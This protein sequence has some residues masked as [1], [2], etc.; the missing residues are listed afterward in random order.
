M[1]KLLYL[2][3]LLPI[4]LWG[5]DGTVLVIDKLAPKNGAF[6]GIVDSSQTVNNVT[7]FN[8]N[9]SASETTVQEALDVLDDLAIGSGGSSVYPA[10]STI[11]ADYGI[12]ASTIQID[13]LSGVLKATGG[14]VSGSATTSDLPEGTN[15]YFTT[16]RATSSIS[17][18]APLTYESGVIG[19]T[20]YF[21]LT[22]S[23]TLL[24][25][26]S[27]TATYL[28][29]SSATETYLQLSSAIATYQ[30]IGSY[31]ESESDPLS[32]L[33]QNT[34]QVGSTFYVS[35]GTVDGNLTVGGNLTV[36]STGYFRG[37]NINAVEIWVSSTST[38]QKTINSITDASASKPYLVHVPP[39]VYNEEITMK[40]Y[41]SLKGSGIDST[42]ISQDEDATINLANET[43]L[44]DMSV[45]ATG[46]DGFA[47]DMLTANAT[48]YL[49]NL[50][51]DG[52]YDCLLVAED[53]I[54]IYAHDIEMLVRYDGV[55]TISGA[56]CN[57]YLFNFVVDLAVADQATFGTF[58]VTATNS[59]F[60]FNPVIRGAITYDG[61]TSRIFQ[62]DNATLNIY[63]PKCELSINLDSANFDAVNSTDSGTVNI[64]SGSIIVTNEG[65]GNTYDLNNSATLNVYGT[66]FSTTHGTITGFGVDDGTLTSFA[67][68]F[69][70]TGAGTFNSILTES[71]DSAGGTVSFSGNDISF[72]IDGVAINFGN[73][74]DANIT[75]DGNSMNLIANAVTNT[76]DM[77]FTAE[78]FTF[79]GS[80]ITFPGLISGSTITFSSG[81]FSGELTAGGI[82]LH[83]AGTIIVAASD[84]RGKTQADYICTGTSDETTINN[85]LTEGAG[86]KVFLLEGTYTIDGSIL[87]PSS[88]TLEGAGYGTFITIEAGTDGLDMISN[89]D[90]T[91]GNSRIRIANLRVD[92]NATQATTAA[93]QNG[94]VFQKVT[95]SIIDGVWAEH[96]GRSDLASCIGIKLWGVD[97]SVI[98]KNIITDTVDGINTMTV[99]DAC[100][101]LTITNN[102]IS[103]TT[104]DYGINLFYIY[105]SIVANNIVRESAKDGIFLNTVCQRNIVANNKVENSSRLTDNTYSGIAVDNQATVA[106]NIIMGNIVR[107]ATSGNN[108]KYG[109]EVQSGALRTRIYHNDLYGSGQTDDYIDAGTNT[110]YVG[111]TTSVVQS[112]YV[113]GNNT[114]LG[115]GV[116]G[117]DYTFTFDG[118]SNDGIITWLEDEGYW[119]LDHDIQFGDDLGI[120]LGATPD[121]KLSFDGTRTNLDTTISGTRHAFLVNGQQMSSVSTTGIGCQA[122]ANGV[123]MEFQADSSGAAGN[124][125][126][127]LM[128][129]KSA[130]FS[131]VAN[132]EMGHAI[133]HSSRDTYLALGTRENGSASAVEHFRVGANGDFKWTPAA[134]T[135]ISQYFTGT[136]NS[137]TYYWMEDEDYFR[138]DDDVLINSTENLYLRDTDISIN[139]ADDGHLD[140][141]ADTS[142]DFNSPIFDLSNQTVAVT[143]NDSVDALNFDSNT[144][145]I[146]ASNGRVGV[147]TASPSTSFHVAGTTS[148]N[149]AQ[150]DTGLDFDLVSAPSALTAT[151]IEDAGGNV[152][153]GDHRY[154]VSYVTDLGETSRGNLSNTV[155]ADAAHTKVSLTNIPVSSDYRVTSRKIYRTIA[156][157]PLYHFK[158]LATI[159]DNVTTTY[160]DN[161]ADGDLTGGASYPGYY[162]LANSTNKLVLVDG[163]ISMVID[164][165]NT[166]FGYQAGDALVAP[167]SQNTVIG[168]SAGTNLTEG[169]YNTLLGH[170]TGR[171]MTTATG[172]TLLGATA[173]YRITGNLNTIIGKFAAYGQTTAVA[174]TMLGAHSG[175]TTSSGGYNTYIG[176]YSGYSG[177]GSSNVFLGRQAGY[178]ETSSN[179]FFVDNQPRTNEA[180][181]RTDALLYGD[182][183]TTVSAQQLTVNAGTFSLNAGTDTDLVVNFKGTTNSGLLTWMEDEDYFKFSDDVQFIDN[184]AIELGTA[185]DATV[186]FD[187]NSLNIVANAVTAT[188][189]LEMTA[190][191]IQ[192]NG[193]VDGP[194]A[195]YKFKLGDS[196]YGSGY[197]F[198]DAETITVGL[199]SA[200]SA[201]YAT[202]GDFLGDIGRTTSAGLF[203]DNGSGNEVIVASTTHALIVTG[204]SYFSSDMQF[205]DDARILL[206]SALTGDC[207]FY[208]DA[209]DLYMDISGAVAT[210][211]T[212]DIVMK[213]ND[214]AGASIFHIFDSDDVTQFNVDSDGNINSNG[215]ISISS[216]IIQNS[217]MKQYSGSKE[218]TDESA[219]GFVDITIGSGEFLGGTILYSIYVTGSGELQSHS[220]SLEFNAI[221]KA[222]TVTS[223]IEETYSPAAESEVVSAGTLTDDYTIT[224]GAGKITINCNANTS[225]GS[226]TITFY[227]TIFLHSGNTITPL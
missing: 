47:L 32:I 173:G 163:Q 129:A 147:G 195:G 15:L 119:N 184:E 99:S 46:V 29:L 159:A 23:T 151:L 132:I 223:D 146:D 58:R 178:Y 89:S 182:F 6:I 17:A 24:T 63:N 115:T 76:D 138:F 109:I 55:V 94:I 51:I 70:T 39:G 198:N 211:G 217:I 148:T 197:F 118:E 209:D 2:L 65:N 128:L 190:E 224:D 8:G 69:L 95:H 153:A 175:Y 86:G 169:T 16:E 41:V 220:G 49:H 196:G 30:P 199:N 165:E 139:S 120:Q 75:F 170:L 150:V 37:L 40:A 85:A 97:D 54:N 221:N 112:D 130:S 61:D 205:P 44:S 88:T 152:T 3:F 194:I 28:Q 127:I 145:S 113:I 135:D 141:A 78:G 193:K 87:V 36:N 189:D 181:G 4:S 203:K 121:S 218:L 74:D 80:S 104:R 172:N 38:I 227:Y 110:I 176:Y 161:S 144:L 79:N 155:T 157:S 219:I 162:Y 214:N 180:T 215:S 156:S 226:P 171:D 206:G 160:E 34:L 126:S 19:A 60:V 96:L 67:G 27:V 43:T 154:F 177:N 64:Y 202:N 207:S 59:M 134:D 222:G 108:Q 35:S 72:G 82:N 137:G 191:T 186:L 57:V 102:I 83:P 12:S 81:T 213:L 136:T 10:T 45:I 188:D 66:K 26:S 225:L 18:T 101:R 9:L 143:L 167:G 122:G 187:G 1:K 105:D 201:I 68:N 25:I 21:L 93:A 33:N 117:V 91:N 62:C 131:A 52:S 124:S 140:V 179:K 192:L 48:C 168:L 71:I 166:A 56:G 84:S 50:Y 174:N 5:A 216:V 164:D 125:A 114:V 11:I 106:D 107:D 98:T 13:S 22:S 31:I 158:L 185:S 20:S 92:G 111:N 149:Y 77:E 142:V 183:S 103:T 116:A 90:T 204:S 100:Y 7:N 208:Y 42:I 53:N 14:D 200:G 210:S 133:N 212:P 123:A 73:A